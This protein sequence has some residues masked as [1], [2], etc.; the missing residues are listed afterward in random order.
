MLK[1]EQEYNSAIIEGCIKEGIEAGFGVAT[2]RSFPATTWF[3][4]RGDR[5]LDFL[6]HLSHPFGEPF[7]QRSRLPIRCSSRQPSTIACLRSKLLK[8]SNKLFHS[9]SSTRPRS[10]SCLAGT[11]RPDTWEIS[12]GPKAYNGGCAP[13]RKTAQGGGSLE[14][15]ARRSTT[16]SRLRCFLKRDRRHMRR[17]R[18]T[19]P[20]CCCA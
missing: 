8:L 20:S 5:R 16:E 19:V 2:G 7:E 10:N 14:L 15:L 9:R 6:N 1:T 13:G 3:R 17:R 11:Y 18:T 4:S 12:Q